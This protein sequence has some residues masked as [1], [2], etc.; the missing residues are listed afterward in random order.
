MPRQ[1]SLKRICQLTVVL[2]RFFFGLVESFPY[3]GADFRFAK[4]AKNRS[5][6]VERIKRV[7]LARPTAILITGEM[8][9]NGHRASIA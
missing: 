5:S 7:T 4:I 1:K 3:G 9:P 6:I 8:P 2:K